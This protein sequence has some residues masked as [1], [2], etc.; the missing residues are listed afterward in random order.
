MPSHTTTEKKLLLYREHPLIVTSR[1]RLLNYRLLFR[2]NAAVC[3]F[4]FLPCFRRLPN[5]CLLR[6][7]FLMNNRLAIHRINY[8]CIISTIICS[9]YVRSSLS[10][11]SSSALHLL[12][13][14]RIDSIINWVATNRVLYEKMSKATLWF[15]VCLSQSIIL[16]WTW[17]I[18]F[19]DI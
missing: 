18:R 9:F 11:Q 8:F 1:N 5:F 7:F 13:C 3:L 10:I 6:A 19:T 2:N 17:T 12:M 4:S 16:C 14:S 15:P